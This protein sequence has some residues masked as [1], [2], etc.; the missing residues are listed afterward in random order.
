M[1]C[2]VMKGSSGGG[3]TQIQARPMPIYISA[4]RGD[5]NVYC[6]C[7]EATCSLSPEYADGSSSLVFLLCALFIRGGFSVN[8]GDL[9]LP[10]SSISISVVTSFVSGYATWLPPPLLC[11][12]ASSPISRTL[13]DHF[14]RP[15]GWKG[16]PMR[17]SISVPT[18]LSF[19]VLDDHS[20]QPRLL[21]LLTLD[22]REIST[23]LPSFSRC[24]SFGRMGSAPK[25]IGSDGRKSGNICRESRSSPRTAGGFG[26]IHSDLSNVREN[27]L[28][29]DFCAA[30]SLDSDSELAWAAW[31][32]W[33]AWL[34]E[35]HH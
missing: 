34:D 27:R 8:F 23:C 9:V 28:L 25:C 1:A 33:L 30:A 14:H 20:I 5:Q 6:H 22:G 31:A 17:L 29:I 18:T 11:T 2:H 24:F 26:G 3:C 12:S 21:L 16:S 19:L 4:R 32:A 10:P 13:V 15:P 7:H 35:A